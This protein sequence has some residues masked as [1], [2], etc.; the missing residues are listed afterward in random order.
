MRLAIGFALT[1]M[2]YE[3]ING[4]GWILLPPSEHTAAS[5]PVYVEYLVDVESASFFYHCKYHGREDSI[6]LDSTARVG[7]GICK[8]T[9]FG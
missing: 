2:L 8:P 9:R 7:E 5:S 1:G 6:M 4:D 3:A